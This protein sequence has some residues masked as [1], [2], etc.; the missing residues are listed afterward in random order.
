VLIEGNSIHEAIIMSD[1][2]RI[3]EVCED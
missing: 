2:L 1:I 3:S